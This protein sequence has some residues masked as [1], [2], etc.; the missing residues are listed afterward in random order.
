MN[1]SL[2]RS[3]RSHATGQ[4]L[5][6]AES[7]FRTEVFGP[8]NQKFASG[9][10]ESQATLP[11]SPVR[12]SRVST[13]A[14][15]MRGRVI[16]SARWAILLL[17]AAS[18]LLIYRPTGISVVGDAVPGGVVSSDEQSSSSLCAGF[19]DEDGSSEAAA[20]HERSTSDDEDEEEDGQ[21]GAMVRRA[22]VR[23]IA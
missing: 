22:I 11:A 13:A 3:T 4:I 19:F 5:L 17:P 16:G 14:L 7:A 9:I 12:R 23:I 10:A 21:S 6:K 2:S 8:K 1:S 15:N 20:L 18:S